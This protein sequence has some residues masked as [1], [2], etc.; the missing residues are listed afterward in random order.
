MFA[1]AI[2]FWL[3]APFAAH[4]DEPCA[5]LDAA[6]QV[7]ELLDPAPD[8]GPIDD[9]TDT[10]DD[11][12]DQVGDRV[13]PVVDDVGNLVDDLLG[14]GGVIDPPDGGILDPPAGGGDHHSGPGIGGPRNGRN[15]PRNVVD[16]TRVVST[17]A[18]E[19][20]PTTDIISAASGTRETPVGS[21]LPPGGIVQAALT[22]AL[23]LLGLFVVAV[24]FVLLQDRLDRGDPKLSIAPVRADVVAFE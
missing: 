6:C 24:G 21:P 12:V 18:R 8:P 15:E 23:L 17:A 5:P 1:G 22:G 14:R 9:V 2:L 19:G 16:P 13:D 11:V 20:A 4:A 3:A 7:D 10:V